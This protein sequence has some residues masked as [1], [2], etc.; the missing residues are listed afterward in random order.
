MSLPNPD[1]VLKNSALLE[2]IRDSL[3]AQKN[4][5]RLS[6]DSLRQT[7]NLQLRAFYPEIAEKN[8]QEE[9]IWT[10]K[11]FAILDEKF[12]A[13]FG[14]HAFLTDY[15]KSQVETL[16]TDAEYAA[17][18]FPTFG[19]RFADALKNAGVKI[20]IP[21]GGLILVVGLVIAAPIV[22]PLLGGAARGAKTI[23]KAAS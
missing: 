20:A 19:E 12:S 16:V 15:D 2:R 18:N 7:I 22:L 9:L 13:E 3:R 14:L 4:G 21:T 8:D 10:V 23:A 5:G 6:T 17:A 1:V 11:A